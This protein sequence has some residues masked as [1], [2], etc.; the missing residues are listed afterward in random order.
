MSSRQDEMRRALD[1]ARSAVEILEQSAKALQL[2][3]DAIAEAATVQQHIEALGAE[4]TALEQRRDVEA[5]ALRDS[6]ER[7]VAQH[8]AAR[9]QAHGQLSVVTRQI[10]DA[11]KRLE[12]LRHTISEET[13]THQAE[14]TKLATLRAELEQEMLLGKASHQQMLIRQEKE[15]T[16]Q[17]ADLQGQRQRAEAELEIAKDKLRD[18]HSSLSTLAPGASTPAP[19]PRGRGRSGAVHE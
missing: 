5:K 9:N 6:H 12:T 2:A 1:R 15:A 3:E 14:L 19:T 17:I 11:E 13:Q 4:V 7:A 16:A 18:F 10:A 8:E